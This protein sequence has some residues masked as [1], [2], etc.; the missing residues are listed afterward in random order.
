[1]ALETS[2]NGG[3]LEDTVPLLIGDLNSVMFAFLLEKRNKPVRVLLSV[4]GI[5]WSFVP[6]FWK[7]ADE[8]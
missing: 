7:W 3:C 4:L 6:R 2:K 8:D 5:A 1:M